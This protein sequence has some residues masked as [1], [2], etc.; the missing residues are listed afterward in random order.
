MSR[1]NRAGFS[2][3]PDDD[4]DS[5][6]IDALTSTRA[7]SA[8]SARQGRVLFELLQQLQEQ[9]GA[10]STKALTITAPIAGDKVPLFYVEE[11]ITLQ[12]LNA[13]VSG[14]TPSVAFLLRYGPDFSATGTEVSDA[15]F[16]VANTT[17]GLEV[18]TFDRPVVPDGS[19]LWLVVSGVSGTVTTFNAS[20]A[21]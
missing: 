3:Q 15:G 9:S 19:W 13:V 10:L 12:R 8:L 7:D 2:V 17:S 14:S 11:S 16:T 5:P 18:T 6:V 20:L 21:F 4:A 1:Q